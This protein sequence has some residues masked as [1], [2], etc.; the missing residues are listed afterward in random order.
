MARSANGAAAARALGGAASSV[1]E[2]IAR[3]F[4]A[5]QIA[6]RGRSSGYI[7]PASHSATPLAGAQKAQ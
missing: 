6:A 1:R 4:P 7:D 2:A 3:R 5:V